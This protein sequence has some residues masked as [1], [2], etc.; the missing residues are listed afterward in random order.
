[1]TLW[2]RIVSFDNLVRAARRAALG[3]RRVRAVARFLDRLEPACLELQRELAHGIWRPGRPLEFRIFDPKERVITAAPFR[4][5]VVHH[6]LIDVLEP[7][8]ERR[9]IHR[10]YA[11][12]RGKGTH[13]ALREAQRLVRA[14]G[15]FLKLDIARC[16]DSLD[17]DVVLGTVGR[18]VRN[19]RVLALCEVI[20]RAGGKDGVGLPIGNLTSQWFCNLVLDRLDHH[21]KEQLRVPGYLRYMDDFVLLGGSKRLLRAAHRELAPWLLHTLALRLKARATILAP[22]REGLPFL[23]WR[24]YRGM[25]R[26]RPENLRRTRRRLQLREKQF[27]RG[28]I[29]ETQLAAC[30]GSVIAHLRSGQTRALRQRIFAT[31]SP[32]RGPQTSATASTAAAAGTTS[33]ATRGPRTAT[34]TGPRTATTTS[35]VVP[36][37]RCLARSRWP[38]ATSGDHRAARVM[39]RPASGAVSAEE[40]SSRRGRAPTGP[41]PPR[42]RD[43]AGTGPATASCRR[44]GKTGGSFGYRALAATPRRRA[45]ARPPA[46]PPA[47]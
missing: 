32:G 31:N 7:I 42:P 20:V 38:R 33:P 22:V 15:W 13:A 47:G 30:T 18:C 23:G 34:G 2:D 39:P 5:R 10:S 36:R 8:F 45:R 26:L 21:V 11:C 19:R 12:R 3:K 24:I 4:D 25:L 40:P 44:D 9:M 43:A 6:A 28:E 41:S 35:A 16:F 1:M 27:L 14:H 37:R 46:G 17:H 29:D